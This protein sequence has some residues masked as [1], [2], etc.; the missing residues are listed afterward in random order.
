MANNFFKTLGWF[1]LI[2]ALQVLMFDHIHILG[3]A[4][5]FVAV[6]FVLLFP[7]D[8]SRSGILLWSF[9]LGLIADTFTNTPGIATIALVT[10]AMVQ[11][12]LLKVNSSIEDD[13]D[14]PVPSA[15]VMGWGAYVIYVTVGTVL[16]EVLLNVLEAFSFFNWADMMLNTA[17]SSLLT[18]LIIVA[19]E[20]IRTSGKRSSNE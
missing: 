17:G 19:I 18:I 15:K 13:D 14:V 6:Y 10:T 2:L 12:W 9:A 11:P 20:R 7:G 5:P 16:C 4:T 1:L 3:H 8:A